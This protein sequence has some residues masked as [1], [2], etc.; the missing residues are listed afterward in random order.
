MPAAPAVPGQCAADASE[1]HRRLSS[2]R[3]GAAAPLIT[4]RFRSSTN[5]FAALCAHW[6]SLHRVVNTTEGKRDDGREEDGRGGPVLSEGKMRSDERS[7]R[8]ARDRRRC[9]GL[10]CKRKEGREEEGKR[11]LLGM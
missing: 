2:S 4:V 9:A 6:R 10:W 1:A 7:A 5:Y 8:E 3:L 11:G